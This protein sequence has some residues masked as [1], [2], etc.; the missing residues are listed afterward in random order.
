MADAIGES[1]EPALV[2]GRGRLLSRRSTRSKG[3]GKGRSRN[4]GTFLA[5]ISVPV[6]LL[7]GVQYMKSRGSRS[8]TKR[9]KT[10][11]NYKN[12]SQKRRRR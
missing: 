4:G 1:D 6:A 10:R 5:E 8:G 2:G 9:R 3:K 7:A 12:K 11:R